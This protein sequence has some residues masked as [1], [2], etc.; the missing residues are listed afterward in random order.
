[1]AGF[2]FLFEGFTLLLGL[3]MAEALGGYAA[4]LKLRARRRMPG[5]SAAD[6]PQRIGLL[7]PLLILV[8]L[9]LLSTFWLDIYQ[10][11]N[12]IPF[13]LASVLVTLL[14]IGGYYVIASLLWPEHPEAWAD[15]DDYY[16]AHRKFVVFA[17]LGLSFAQGLL[18]ALVGVEFPEPPPP[19][20]LE[21]LQLLADWGE[22]V[23]FAAF[24]A[25]AFVRGRR[26]SL[27]LLLVSVAVLGLDALASAL[28]VGMYVAVVAG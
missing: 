25:L 15:L 4:M 23:S 20:G 3:A 27:L 14:F 19:P 6:N 28:G 17:L 7:L 24:L 16:L 9:G 11:Q 8:V 12:Q 10:A 13:N 21:R 22:L 18:L 5:A 2:D 26:A 1:M